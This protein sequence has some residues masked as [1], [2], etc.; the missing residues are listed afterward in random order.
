MNIIEL[1][2]DVIE[3][4]KLTAEEILFA[5]LHP[6]WAAASDKFSGWRAGE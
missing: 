4:K 1:A 5:A 3:V 2:G 6:E